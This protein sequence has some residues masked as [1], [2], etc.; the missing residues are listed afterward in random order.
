MNSYSNGPA[1]GP[2][3]DPKMIV[4][5]QATVILNYTHDVEEYKRRMELLKTV[6]PDG[7][8]GQI[9]LYRNAHIGREDSLPLEAEM[10]FMRVHK[11]LSYRNSKGDIIE[12]QAYRPVSLEDNLPYVFTTLNGV[13]VNPLKQF[14]VTNEVFKNLPPSKQQAYIRSM[15]RFIGL[16]QTSALQT[17]PSNERRDIPIQLG[18]VKHFYNDSKNTFNIGDYAVWNVPEPGME[19]E[20]PP[21]GSFATR[22]AAGKEAPNKRRFILEKYEPANLITENSIKNFYQTNPIIAGKIINGATKQEAINEIQKLRTGE[23]I[24]VTADDVIA[25]LLILLIDS[26]KVSNV[27]F[28]AH[29]V[30]YLKNPVELHKKTVIFMKGVF[31]VQQEYSS[32]IVG[33]VLRTIEPGGIGAIWLTGSHV[34]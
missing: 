12:R 20:Y 11:D 32:R 9:E 5:P 28:N 19:R 22:T 8:M 21:M 15:F 29:E 33:K 14:G 3:M 18:G 13:S 17:Q 30:N 27:N 7:S 25:D 4:M 26:M 34:V 10:A 6:E 2:G 31:S 16:I 1:R 23:Q 24:A